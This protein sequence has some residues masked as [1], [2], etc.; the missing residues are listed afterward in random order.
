M[1]LAVTDTGSGVA[2][3][4][5]DRSFEPLVTGRPEGTGLGLALARELAE[6]QGGRMRLLS[7]GGA[8]DGGAVF[9]LELP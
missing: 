3:E 9:A 5:R 1:R 6:A 2:P 7:P 8:G 4:L